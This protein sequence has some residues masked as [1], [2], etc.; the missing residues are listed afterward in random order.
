MARWYSCN[1]LQP[2]GQLRQLWQFNSAG[3]KF[4]LLRQETKLPSEP[5]PEKLIAKDWQTLFQPRLNVAWLPADRVFLRVLQIPKADLAE[6][7]SMV[8]LQLEKVSPLPVAQIVWSFQ[9]VP[10]V[11]QSGL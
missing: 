7:Q 10:M 1:V 4:N 9:V 11:R 6:T 3:S 2:G 5:L 8:E